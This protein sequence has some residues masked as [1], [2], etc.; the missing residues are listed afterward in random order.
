MPPARERQAIHVLA[1]D[2]EQ[3]QDLEDS[4][5]PKEKVAILDAALIPRC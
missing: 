1:L 3:I 4:R 5:S 2:A